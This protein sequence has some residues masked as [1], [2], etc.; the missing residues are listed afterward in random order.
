M[1]SDKPP[2]R[3]LRFQ[4]KPQNRRKTR[5]S[6]VPKTENVDEDREEVSEAKQRLLRRFDEHLRQQQPKVEIPAQVAFTYES[7]QVTTTRVSDRL[8]VGSHNQRSGL[9]LME[10]DDDTGQSSDSSCSVAGSMETYLEPWDYTS[11]Y[12]NPIPWRVPY[13]GNPEILNVAE[14]GALGREVEYDETTINPASALGFLNPDESGENNR[15]L[16]FQLPQSLPAMKRLASAK[17]KEKAG[18]YPTPVQKGSLA[19]AQDG[20][21]ITGGTSQRTS[22]LED[23]S[24]GLMGKLLIHKSGAVK[25]KL[26]DILYSVSPGIDCTIAQD[27]AGID[28]KR[29]TLCEIGNLDGKAVIALDIDYLLDSVID[30]D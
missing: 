12:P 15:L 7:N 2:P 23:L 5:S 21:S 6:A 27:V 1:D 20:S 26:G 19:L 18:S 16:F 11:Y 17:G 3:K 14:F 24:E 9:D 13:S 10:F 28:T 29:K 30:L 8:R 25:L 22:S 4:P